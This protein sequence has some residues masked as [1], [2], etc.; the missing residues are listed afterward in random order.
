MATISEIEAQLNVVTAWMNA[1]IAGG[2]TIAE[3]PAASTLESTGEVAVINAGVTEKATVQ[4]FTDK[5]DGVV[6]YIA[7][8][9]FIL[10]KHNL[11]NLEANRRI[12]QTNDTIEGSNSSGNMMRAIYLGGDSTDFENPAVYNN[13]GGWTF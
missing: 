8:V 1:V 13:L 7:G 6:I 2:K 10:I 4:Q 9:R 5:A 12:L 3:L 11:N